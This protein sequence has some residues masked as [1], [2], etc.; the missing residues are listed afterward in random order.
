MS[1]KVY[2]AYRFPRSLDVMKFQERVRELANPVRDRMDATEVVRRTTDTVAHDAFF[3][4]HKRDGRGGYDFL[5]EAGPVAFACVDYSEEQ[6]KEDRHS[7][8]HDPHRLEMSIVAHG[9]WVGVKAF[10]SRRDYEPVIEQLCDEFGGEE[11]HYQNQTERP[12]SLTEAEWDERR[13]F[14]DAA[15]SDPPWNERGLSF[16]LRGE[17]S[18]AMI[19][20]EGIR[21]AADESMLPSRQSQVKVA[22]RTLV[23]RAAREEYGA[24]RAFRL[25][26]VSEYPSRLFELIDAVM[27]DITLSRLFEPMP[28]PDMPLATDDMRQ[29]AALAV[30]RI[31][32]D[33]S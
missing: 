3:V 25:M 10:T 9:D 6:R 18:L 29:L 7:T 14:W 8:F 22:A 27:P 26:D 21:A 33:A 4:S 32:A 28:R 5:A 23:L 2:D 20:P 30:S 12:D 24:S 16:V 1:T 31:L 13:D 15:L 17:M 19:F 11:F